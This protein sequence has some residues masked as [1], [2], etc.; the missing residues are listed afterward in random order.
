MNGLLCQLADKWPAAGTIGQLLVAH[1]D[2]DS[3]QMASYF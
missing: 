2:C 1:H 3:K